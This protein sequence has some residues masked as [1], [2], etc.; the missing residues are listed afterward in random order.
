MS[1]E[2]EMGTA[3][4]PDRAGFIYTFYSY[5][6]GT[7]RSMALANVAVLM[8]NRGHRVLTIDWDLE[9]PGLEKYFENLKPGLVERRKRTD[10]VIDFIERWIVAHASW[11][12]RYEQWRADDDTRAEARRPFEKV[13]QEL[14]RAMETASA[15]AHLEEL[16]AKRDAAEAHLR[17]VDDGMTKKYPAG[18]PKPEAPDWRK[19]I[20]QLARP[21]SGG[22]LDFLSAGRDKPGYSSRVNSL[23]WDALFSEHELGLYLEQLRDDWRTAYDFVLVDSRTGISDI[24]GICTVLLPDCLV[25]V[26]TTMAQSVQGVL[27][28]WENSATERA[29]LPVARGRLLALPLPSRDEIDRENEL[30]DEWH[31]RFAEQFEGVYRQ[32]LPKRVRTLDAV[33]QLA[34]PYVARWSFGERLPVAENA[35]DLANPRSINAAYDRVARLLAYR[36]S[37]SRAISAGSDVRYKTGSDLLRRKTATAVGPATVVREHKR[38][39]KVRAEDGIMDATV[40]L[41]G[42]D[43]TGPVRL[44][45]LTLPYGEIRAD[46]RAM[47]ELPVLEETLDDGRRRYTLV[48]VPGTYERVAWQFH[49]SNAVALTRADSR[50]MRALDRSS[51]RELRPDEEGRSYIVHF[52][53]DRLILSMIFESYYDVIEI[54]SGRVIVEQRDYQ[55]N[56][57]ERWKSVPDEEER[58][59]EFITVDARSIRLNITNP[60]VG[61]RYT[62]VFRLSHEGENNHPDADRIATSLLERVLT[63]TALDNDSAISA[64][65]TRM[66]EPEIARVLRGSNAAK[67]SMLGSDWSGDGAAWLGT[68]WNA[69]CRALL[70]AFGRFPTASWAVRFP[71]GRGV[72]GQSFRFRAPAA[73]YSGVKESLIYQPT[74]QLAGPFHAPYQWVVS[75]PIQ[76]PGYA[77]IGVVSFA[78]KDRKAATTRRLAQLAE[79]IVERRANLQLAS[80]LQSVI[81]ACFWHGVVA[82]KLDRTGAAEEILLHLTRG[83]SI[84][85]GQSSAKKTRGAAGTTTRKG[86]HHRSNKGKSSTPPRRGGKRRAS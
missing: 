66:M 39:W 9:A 45:I 15:D 72:A 68:I 20:I 79:D 62:P 24:E 82:E 8:A 44:A 59:L 19:G 65:F 58:C 5:K 42:L 63:E 61:F 34:L 78:G 69:S 31:A 37:W 70:P 23:R 36:L 47:P 46:V 10:G 75:L 73:W 67:A 6:G 76:I 12:P 33:K 4:S 56:D 50:D 41:K 25:L 27:D 26:F 29:R 77:P 43:L 3:T 60:V 18:R 85:S 11:V 55:N 21:T 13:Q 22:A 57:D 40:E 84:R 35:A 16:R 71:S 14:A 38:T 17:S 2:I 86:E 1:D 64:R 52:Q 53:C 54:G 80:D 49:L 51:P 28:V 32:W 81:A 48:A 30:A 74:A 7:G 83:P